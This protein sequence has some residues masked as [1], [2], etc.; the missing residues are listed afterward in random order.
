[1]RVDVLS[2]VRKESSEFSLSRQD[3]DEP[4]MAISL[5][6]FSRPQKTKKVQPRQVWAQQLGKYV[7]PKSVFL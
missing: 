3:E 1:M 4:E 7:T 5:P 2:S 6:V